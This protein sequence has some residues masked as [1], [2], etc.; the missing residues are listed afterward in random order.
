VRSKSSDDVSQLQWNGESAK[1]QSD[2]LS[3]IASHPEE[4]W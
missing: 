3:R 2:L 4:E 1:L